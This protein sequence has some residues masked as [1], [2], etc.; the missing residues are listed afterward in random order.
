MVALVAEWPGALPECPGLLETELE[1]PL[2]CTAVGAGTA[3]AWRPRARLGMRVRAGTDDRVR[4]G[5][6]TPRCCTARSAGD[7]ADAG[8]PR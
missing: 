4:T 8:V 6:G 7:T 3:V 1:E 5:T 2:A